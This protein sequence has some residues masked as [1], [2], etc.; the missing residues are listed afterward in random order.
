MLPGKEIG[1]RATTVLGGI[2]II[3]PPEMRVVDSGIAILGGR[4]IVGNS[5]EAS[6]PDAPVLRIE[7]ACILGG[8]EVKRKPRKPPKALKRGKGLNISLETN[9]VPVIRIRSA[10]KDE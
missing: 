8:I 7:G 10:D 9:R 6:S 5:A 3:V 1:I 4:E 2:E